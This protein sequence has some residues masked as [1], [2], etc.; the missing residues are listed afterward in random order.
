MSCVGLEKCSNLES[1]LGFLSTSW[2]AL[3]V[4]LSEDYQTRL[5]G[6]CIYLKHDKAFL[7]N[8]SIE[9]GKM[10]FPLSF[11]SLHPGMSL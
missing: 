5:L 4:Y 11:Q 3:T 1:L 8:I 9:I 10:I 7:R 2:I 6:L